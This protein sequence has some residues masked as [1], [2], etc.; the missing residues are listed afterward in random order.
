V[1]IGGMRPVLCCR[2]VEVQTRAVR[3]KGPAG[4]QGL[5]VLDH[6]CV[7][8]RELRSSRMDL[9]CLA[10]LDI[11]PFGV[12][13]SSLRR[14][15]EPGPREP[16][17]SNLNRPQPKDCRGHILWP[18]NDNGRPL[19]LR[20]PFKTFFPCKRRLSCISS[21]SGSEKATHRNREKLYE[22]GVCPLINVTRRRS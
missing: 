18:R 14:H 11:R 6:C 16:K 17:R 1:N 15:C 13:L 20:R 22:I 12:P 2:V 9:F 10:P 8:S 19:G 4:W 7:L 5:S 3:K 21:D